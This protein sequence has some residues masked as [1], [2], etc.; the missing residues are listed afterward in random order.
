[1]KAERRDKFAFSIAASRSPGHS[2][3]RSERAGNVGRL[4]SIPVIK[5]SPGNSIIRI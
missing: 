2:P 5:S 3:F 4:R 1:M